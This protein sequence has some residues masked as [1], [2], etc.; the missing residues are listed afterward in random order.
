LVNAE[1]ARAV[2]TESAEAL[3]H[4]FG[5]SAKVVWKWRKAFGVGGS[6]TTPGSM[7]A[8]RAAS[9]KGA[10]AIKAKKW[11]DEELAT[12]AAVAKKHGLKP[13][14]RWTPITGGWTADQVALLGTDHDK[15]IAEKLHRSVNAVRLKRER[16]KI[17]RARAAVG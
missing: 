5:V 1:L 16:L 14:P 13:G 17:P 3:M 9:L 10:A 11:T 2:K 12:K 7:N 8:T 4:W 15:H 6:A